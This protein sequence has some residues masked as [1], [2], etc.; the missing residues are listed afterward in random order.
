MNYGSGLTGLNLKEMLSRCR[1]ARKVT[2]NANV[3]QSLQ[4]CWVGLAV[5]KWIFVILYHNVLAITTIGHDNIFLSC[6]DF[7]TMDY[8]QFDRCK[9]HKPP[10]FPQSLQL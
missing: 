9:E 5:Y 2:V 4:P 10:S 1:A 6:K 7:G 3:K 8:G